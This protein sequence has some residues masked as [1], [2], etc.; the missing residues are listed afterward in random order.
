MTQAVRTLLSSS[1]QPAASQ[2]PQ[3]RRATAIKLMQD[4]GDFAKSECVP[5]LRLFTSSINVVDSYLA[6]EDK[7]IRTMYIKGFLESP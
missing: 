2:L 5:V 3:E 4:D 7:E 1:L 6:I